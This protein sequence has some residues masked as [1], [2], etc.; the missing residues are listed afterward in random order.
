MTYTCQFVINNIKSL[1]Q[2]PLPTIMK[3]GRENVI[4]I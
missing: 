1:Q 3:L 4:V 2:L